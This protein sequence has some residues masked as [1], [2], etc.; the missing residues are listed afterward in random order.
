V[1]HL[2][3]VTPLG[4]LLALPINIRLGWKGLPG[5]NTLTYNKKLEIMGVESF[6]TLGPGELYAGQASR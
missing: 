4:S 1:K 3:G 6:I 5:T 2:S